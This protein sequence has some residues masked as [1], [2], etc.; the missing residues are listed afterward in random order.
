MVTQ[1]G[2]RTPASHFDAVPNDARKE[3]PKKK[4]TT[5]GAEFKPALPCSSQPSRGTVASRCEASSVA[6][7]L[8][9]RLA[10]AA[11]PKE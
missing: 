5:A 1:R 7:S 8:S 11:A 2:K 3:Q 6:R 10:K 4:A 9:D